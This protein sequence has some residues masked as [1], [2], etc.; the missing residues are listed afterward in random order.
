MI[1]GNVSDDSLQRQLENEFS[2][3]GVAIERLTF[4][5]KKSIS[6]YLALHGE[7][8][9]I[10]DT[11][12]YSGGTTTGFAIWMGVPTLTYA[13][14][15][16]AGRQGVSML[17]FVDLHDLFTAKTTEQF[18]EMAKNWVQRIDELQ[19]LRYQLRDSMKN[20][21]NQNLSACFKSQKSALKPSEPQVY[22]RNMYERRT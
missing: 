22:H 2:K 21:K 4:Y 14:N 13:W 16:L 7:V 5:A 12:P 18:I 9:F 10:L 19:I 17:S 20:S 15:T 6:D 8:D 1:L 3:R 11:F